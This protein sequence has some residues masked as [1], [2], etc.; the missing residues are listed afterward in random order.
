MFLE[1]LYIVAKHWLEQIAG[2]RKKKV[3][4]V[5]WVFSMCQT[6]DPTELQ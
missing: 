4:V 1:F 3:L 6:I 2:R 5:S